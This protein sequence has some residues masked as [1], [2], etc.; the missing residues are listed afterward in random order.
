MTAARY[1]SKSHPALELLSDY[2]LGRLD[3]AELEGIAEHLDQCDDCQ[4]T[5]TSLASEDTLV[6][7]LA[8]EFETSS[9]ESEADLAAV[10]E[11][12]KEKPREETLDFQ[13]GQNDPEDAITPQTLRDYRLLEKLGS[14]GM[15][16]VYRAKHE[17]LGRQVALKVLPRERMRQPQAIAR[18]AREMQAVGNL[19]HPHI[20]RAFDAGEI[21]GKHFLAMELIDGIDL[22]A[23]SKQQGQLS[24]GIACELVR[25]AALGLQYAHDQ[26]LVHRDVKPSNL[27]LD[28]TGTVKVLDLGL[29]RLLSDS[30]DELHPD[31][32]D[33]HSLEGSNFQTLDPILTGTDQVMGTPDY[34]APEQCTGAKVDARS[35]VFSL[36]ATLYKLLTGHAPYSGSEFN[37]LAKKITGL[38]ERPVPPVTTHRQ[39]LPTKLVKLIEKMLEKDPDRRP[40]TAAEVAMLL[41]PLASATKV[42]D[43]LTTLHGEDASVTDKVPPSLESS[44]P[45]GF[46]RKWLVGAAF[47]GFLVAAV[48]LLKLQTPEGQL[49]VEVPPEARDQ[50]QVEVRQGDQIKVLNPEEGWEARLDEGNW[51]IM[52]KNAGDDLKLDKD[53]VTIQRGEQELVRIVLDR[54]KATNRQVKAAEVSVLDLTADPKRSEWS[55]DCT[56]YTKAY[57]LDGNQTIDLGD[58]LRWQVRSEYRG[59]TPQGPVVDPR[60]TIALVDDSKNFWPMIMKLSLEQARGFQGVVA[61]VS[62][63]RMLQA[64]PHR[65]SAT[66]DVEQLP[67]DE[68]GRIQLPEDAWFSFGKSSDKSDRFPLELKVYPQAKQR[69]NPICTAKMSHA[70]G[71]RLA[72]Q[73]KQAV[74]IKK[75]EQAL[76]RQ[77][78]GVLRRFSPIVDAPISEHKRVVKERD[79][80]G[81]VASEWQFNPTEPTTLRL[82]EINKPE[83]VENCVVTFRAKM[84]T[85]DLEGKAYLEMWVR[86]PPNPEAFSKGFHHAV[87]G[88]ND[89]ATYETPFFLKKGEQADLLKLNVVTE[90]A[91][92]IFLNDVEVIVAPMPGSPSAEAKR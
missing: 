33:G 55:L 75:R 80:G 89:W 84:K 5:L 70:I 45:S 81:Y 8:M 90:G 31:G 6:R 50:V 48:V 12:L 83:N 21:D 71:L 62:E 72:S 43:L 7:G 53:Q 30:G 34:M 74:E 26:G 79:G 39:D 32:S 42:Q 36:G 19:D 46:G 11:S 24:V 28:R 38:T 40:Q 54:K 23:L 20:V 2:A 59:N 60:I 82:F 41:E 91:G 68:I 10:L 44:P 49:T 66:M 64:M 58:K 35:D 61:S 27:M 37:T 92:T 1:Q 86:V 9:Y 78:P 52:L 63:K 14:G 17:R 4:E 87:S 67:R 25:Q 16:T 18:F 56:L 3:E 88:T 57:K 47:F 22:S 76:K 51:E 85:K 73:L 69:K 77:E 65:L 29:A 13:R 15:G